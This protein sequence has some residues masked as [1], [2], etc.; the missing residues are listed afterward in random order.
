[1]KPLKGTDILK[2][3]SIN[4]IASN[5]SIYLALP[6]TTYRYQ[7]DTESIENVPM[8][9]PALHLEPSVHFMSSFFTHLYFL[10]TAENRSCCF[11]LLSHFFF[12][13]FCLP[14]FSFSLPLPKCPQQEPPPY[15]PQ[16][17]IFPVF[18]SLYSMVT[19]HHV[20]FSGLHLSPQM[21]F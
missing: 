2:H 13:F 3:N 10:V 7:Y 11:S 8:W 6:N 1:M 20:R 21:D 18:Q 4:D 15:H 14:W 19:K 17:K 16:P 9:M 5:D 12:V